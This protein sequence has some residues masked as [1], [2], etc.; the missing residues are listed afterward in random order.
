MVRYDAGTD[1]IVD[2]LVGVYSAG[3][4]AINI[5]AGEQFALAQQL[6]TNAAAKLHEA[7][8]KRRTTDDKLPEI[9][10]HAW[11]TMWNMSHGL[12]P[13][14]EYITASPEDTKPLGNVVEII[15]T[16][17]KTIPNRGFFVF[18]QPDLAFPFFPEAALLIR[19][20]ISEQ[21]AVCKAH[22]RCM[23]FI[24]IGDVMPADLKQYMPTIHLPKPNE[25]R[26]MSIVESAAGASKTVREDVKKQL[27]ASLRG[28]GDQDTVNLLGLAV[29]QTGGMLPATV[30]KVEELKA[31]AIGNSGCLEY[32][33]KSKIE[34]L[35][36][37]AGYDVLRTWIKARKPAMDCASDQLDP[38]KGAMLLGVPGTGKSVAGKLIAKDLGRPFIR[39]DLAGVYGSLV[40]ESESKTRQAIATIT[41]QRGCVLMLDEVDKLLGGSH[42]AK[43]DSGVT[44][45]VLGTILTWLSD[46]KDETFVL[47]TANR[48]EGL[49]IELTRKGR[50]D[51]IFFVDTPGPDQRKQIFEIHLKHRK[52]DTSKYTM[53]NWK[54]IVKASEG[55]VGAEIE[56]AVSEAILQAYAGGR[57]DGWVIPTERELITAITSSPSMLEK[58]S[59]DIDK[60]R[61]WGKKHARN[62]CEITS[63]TYG[64]DLSQTGREFAAEM[65]N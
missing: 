4:Q 23:V 8:S 56:A 32:I 16:P 58:S 53:A 7:Y 24:T 3:Y 10:K 41:A 11:V 65:N 35:P 42:E 30:A 39:F 54:A 6:I 29:V 9:P 37:V 38:V 34:L 45:R 61:K 19:K 33:P 57:T 31:A 64:E 17:N 36:E 59:A 21:R 2:M 25:A 20:A 22:R 46:K 44:Q 62:V 60:I 13:N 48:I 28:L 51:E 26:I 18:E 12:Y 14:S 27:T 50:L 5:V 52:V 40:G 63:N 1:E 43:G 55:Y 47:M 15:S 49:P